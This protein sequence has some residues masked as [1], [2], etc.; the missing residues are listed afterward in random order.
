MASSWVRWASSRASW[1]E[2]TLWAAFASRRGVLVLG[3]GETALRV[4]DRAPV[5]TQDIAR[6]AGIGVARQLVLGIADGAPRLGQATGSWMPWS[7]SGCAWHRRATSGPSGARTRRQPGHRRSAWPG[8]RRACALPGRKVA[9]CLLREPGSASGAVG[10]G[11][12]RAL[13]HPVAQRGVHRGHRPG[14]AGRRPGAGGAGRD[15]APRPARTRGPR[16]RWRRHCPV[17][18]RLLGHVVGAWRWR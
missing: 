2:A 17:A 10:R 5:G 6:G 9:L 3:G 15:D 7:P 11:Q 16:W 18:T 12:D 1:A 8:R 13:G 4:A 14:P